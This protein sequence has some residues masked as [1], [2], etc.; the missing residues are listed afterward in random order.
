M[1]LTRKSE[2]PPP[3]VFLAGFLTAILA[4][5]WMVAGSTQFFVITPQQLVFIGTLG[6]GAAAATLWWYRATAL[7]VWWIIASAA[8][9]RLL[10][11]GG[12]PL[13]EDDYFRYL[14]DGMQLV[15]TGDPYSIAPSAWFGDTGLTERWDAILSRINYPDI[16]TVYGPV[17]HWLFSLGYLIAPGAVWPLQLMAALADFGIVVLLTRSAGSRGALPVNLILL[18]AWSPLLLKEFALSAHPDSIAVMLLLLAFRCGSA[19]KLLI[20]GTLGGL[21]VGVKVFALIG[22]PFLMIRGAAN[23]QPSMP[24][25][26]LVA[27][28]LFALGAITLYYGDLSIWFPE[29][30]STMASSWLFNAPLYQLM[31]PLLGF[32]SIKLLLLTMFAGVAT[33]SWFKVIRHPTRNPAPALAVLFGILLLAIPVLNPWYLVW[34]LGFAVWRPWRWPWVASVSVLLAYSSGYG[35]GAA[36]DALYQLP[37][38]LLAAEFGAVGLAVVSDLIHPARPANTREQC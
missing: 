37:G 32:N 38:W 34:V 20:A 16:R 10:C 25:V 17:L 29:G 14:W 22:I 7:P 13:F 5:L 3:T 6:T 4:T 30:L 12:Q 24:V 2:T 23:A 35:S 36:D 21:A 27:G 8:V 19:G 28:F 26:R 11:L 1:I 9:L 33:L 18:Y 15:T 31:L